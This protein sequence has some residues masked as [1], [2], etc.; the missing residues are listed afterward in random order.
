ME[1]ENPRTELELLRLSIVNAGEQEDQH[2]HSHQAWEYRMVDKL[3]T[4]GPSHVVQC[5]RHNTGSVHIRPT[6]VTTE[7]HPNLKSGTFFSSFIF[8]FVYLAYM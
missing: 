8:Y 3:Q 6:S 4:L 7:S 2:E 1:S 5:W